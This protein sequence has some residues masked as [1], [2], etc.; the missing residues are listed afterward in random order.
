MK[1]KFCGKEVEIPFKCNFCG[2]YFCLGHRLPESHNCS[3]APPRTPLGSWETKQKLRMAKE[4]KKKEKSMMISEGDF[5]FI[6]KEIPL[7]D[8]KRLMSNKEEKKSRFSLFKRKKG[9]C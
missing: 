3:E 4:E 1:C 9:K 8:T 2:N 7:V 6:K 5:H